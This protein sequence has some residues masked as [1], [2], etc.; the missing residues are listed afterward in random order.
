MHTA[1]TVIPGATESCRAC[2]VVD[3]RN[4]SRSPF[5]AGDVRLPAGATFAGN[6]SNEERWRY[7]TPYDD[8]IA[9]LRMQ[10]ATGRK[11]DAN[12]AT[13]WRDLPPCYNDKH[14]RPPG[15]WVMDDATFWLWTDGSNSLSVQVYRPTSKSTPNE[16]VIDYRRWDHAYPC[17]RD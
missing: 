10:F 12:G 9:F 7:T 16:I 8:T 2:T 3:G 11:Y 14:E 17:Y 15:G 1:R 13:S 5:T 6:S 4:P